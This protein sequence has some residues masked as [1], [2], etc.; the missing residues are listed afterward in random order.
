MQKA[1]VVRF[2]SK[3][4]K[5]TQDM[6]FLARVLV[7][8]CVLGYQKKKKSFLNSQF[9]IPPYKKCFPFSCFIE[10]VTIDLFMIYIFNLII[11][12]SQKPQLSETTTHYL[13]T[14][15]LFLIKVSIIEWK[16]AWIIVSIPLVLRAFRKL[17]KRLWCNSAPNCCE[18][19]LT[20]LLL[21][22]LVI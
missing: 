11:L 2:P 9:R 19:W 18:Y 1:K 21:L 6:T 4:E 17:Y 8:E 15:P 16:S 13:I 7:V 12:N 10:Q 14:T 22:F 20:F 5:I 3:S